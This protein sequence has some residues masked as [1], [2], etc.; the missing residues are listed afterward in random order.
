M[1]QIE[2]K[3]LTF[4]YTDAKTGNYLEEK[5]LDD[6]CLDI[7]QGEFV[8]VCG[9]TGCG[10]STLLRNLKPSIRPKGEITGE[11][12]YEQCPVDELKDKDAA[13]KI[14]FVMQNPEHQI[15]TDSV[16]HELAFGLESLGYPS[17]EIRL[18]TAEI[19]EYFQIMDLYFKKTDAIVWRTGNANFKSGVNHGNAAK[20]ACFR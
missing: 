5:A 1:A 20:G 16:W 9:K 11:L 19:A 12:F 4:R 15:V 7:E 3:N 18:R 8:V 17:E 10:K 13:E 2:I 6:V 14:G